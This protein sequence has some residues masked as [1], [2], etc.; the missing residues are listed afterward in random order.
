MTAQAE[1]TAPNSE[2]W[3]KVLTEGHR[4]IR[5]QQ[6][7]FRYLPGPPRCKVCFNPFGGIGGKLVGLA[8]YTP[9]RK[10]PNLCARCCENLP[11]GGAE[12]DI[13]VLFADLRGSTTLGEQ[14]GPAAYAA[15][16]NRF[17]ATATEVLVGHD[18]IIDK[19][20]GDEVMALFI[21]GICGREYHRRAAEAAFALV[22][23]IAGVSSGG[24][25]MPLGT[26]VHSGLTFVGNVG[27][28]VVDFTAL[29]DTVNTASRLASSAGPGEVLLGEVVYAAVAERFPDLE[30]RTL[31]LRG[32]DVQIPVR[33]WRPQATVPLSFRQGAD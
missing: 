5:I 25:G 13:A 23:S 16:L 20:I 19:L 28:E 11:P 15:I 1:I 33:V 29:G 27:G 17:Y 14:L 9:S 10:N 7:L 24:L 2:L 30:R 31:T 22:Q 6:V 8:G 4:A 18:A 3:R 12:V 32:K 26:A 21:P